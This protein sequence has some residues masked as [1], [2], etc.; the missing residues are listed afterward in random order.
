MPRRA[1]LHPSSLDTAAAMAASPPAESS[2]ATRH[3]TTKH[4]RPLAEDENFDP[5][6]SSTQVVANAINSGES[7]SDQKVKVARKVKR[8]ERFND[9]DSPVTV[10]SRTPP[11]VAV[12]SITL[13]SAAEPDTA[14]APCES[15]STR[16]SPVTVTAPNAFAAPITPQPSKRATADV[17]KPSRREK[18]M[19]APS[20]AS[21]QLEIFD[22]EFEAQS[23]AADSSIPE[24][25]PDFD[26]A[27]ELVYQKTEEEVMLDIMRGFEDEMGPDV[28]AVW[29]A[30]G[31][32]EPIESSL[33]WDV[34][35]T[36]NMMKDYAKLVAKGPSE[37][38]DSN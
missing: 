15:S 10:P 3:A 13:S 38:T 35:A 6:P 16:S 30:A 20:E 27:C 23:A 26:H 21:V 28:R 8:P 11:P 37:A 5:A 18:P 19:G 7:I 14:K 12:Q 36:P 9:G 29:D 32:A 33:L 17:E 4:K 22:F 25:N 24:I 1:T 34:V 2:A 31:K